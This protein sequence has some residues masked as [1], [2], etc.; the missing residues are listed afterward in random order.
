MAEVIVVGGGIIGMSVAYRLT[1]AGADVV[2]LEADRLGGGTSGSSFAWI[3]ANNKAPFEY[4]RLNVAGMAEHSL[5]QAEFGAAPWLH[6]HGNVIWEDSSAGQDSTEPDVPA[7]VDSL[8]EK[9]RRL[10]EWGYPVQVLSAREL[11][12]VYPDLAVPP[13]VDWVASFPNEGF[14]DV[15]QLIA[16][17]A[18]ATVRLGAKL[19][20]HTKVVEIRRRGSRVVGVRTADGEQYFADVVV[21][22]TGRWTDELTQLA[23]CQIPMAPTLG[24]LVV[25]TPVVTRFRGLVHTP[26]VNL[27]PDGGS[28]L[29]MASFEIDRKLHQSTTPEML[30]QF[31]NQIFTRARTILPAL[32]G[33]SV[34]SFKVGV[35]SIPKDAFPVVGPIKGLEGFYVIATHSGVT[36]GPVLGRIAAKEILTSE[37]DDRLEP[38]RPDR[39][40]GQNTDQASSGVHPG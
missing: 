24:L 10:R 33:A 32:E 29:L 31:A 21:S 2:L 22:C 23:G 35:R 19:H 26:S 17:L 7:R 9:V 38:F 15:P 34:E 30:Q 6:L 20:T 13:D 25:S 39:L 16:V 3:N 28:R 40:I 12:E 18:D 1:R 4:H 37:T 36:L 5:L 11:L 27:R 14:V 8:A